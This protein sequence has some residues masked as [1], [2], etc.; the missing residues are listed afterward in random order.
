ME[1][2]LLADDLTGACDAAVHF[3]LRGY[4]TVASV[5]LAE[6]DLDADVLAVSTDSRDFDREAI[7]ELLSEAGRIWAGAPPRVLFK[8]IDST[9]RGNAG[10]EIGAAMEAFGCDRAVITPAFPALGRIVRDGW[11]CLPRDPDFQPILGTDWLRSQ[12]LDCGGRMVWADAATD[13]DLDRIV[14]DF[15]KP[16]GRILWAG[17]GGLAA[18]VARALPPGR[19]GRPAA[20]TAR[21]PVLFCVGSD[22]KVTVAQEEA[23]VR[24]RRAV[25][26]PGESGGPEQ[27]IAA[28]G[29]GEQVVLTIPR[30][31]VPAGR[32][33]ELI[34]AAPAAAL[35][36]T[37]G[38]TASLVCRAMG[39]GRIE[40]IDQIVPGLPVGVLRGGELD[41]LPVAT[42][43][44]GFGE[45]D[46]LL[47]VADYF[48]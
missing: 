38:D 10:M 6:R 41:G 15:L 48:D 39:A 28:L 30:G 24:G 4:R 23:L 40:L 14:A 11:L 32:I 35:L 9:L 45:V 3:A 1:C 47:K 8:K 18:A 29:R 7:R 20:C 34:G 12:G 26:V 27:V 17:S 13:R 25:R 22:H 33:A 44:G 2:L 31:R 19:H 46:A 37:G 5:S 43:S 21:G 16:G 36:L 42:K